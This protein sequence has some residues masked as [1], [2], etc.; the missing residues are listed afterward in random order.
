MDGE[1]LSDDLGGSVSL[2]G[3]MNGDG[4]ADL[5]VA[6]KLADPSGYSS[7]RSYVVFGKAGTDPV[8]P[9]DLAGGSGGFVID[10]EAEEHH[11]GAS[12]SAAGDVDGDGLADVVLGAPYA[13]PNDAYWAG[14]GYV[15]WGKTTTL[16]VQ[17]ALVA[18]G[19]GGFVIDGEYAGANSGLAVSGAG[20]VNGDGLADVIVAAPA[21]TP[22]GNDSGRTYV[23]FG[24]ANNTGVVLADVAA[25]LGGFAMDGEAADDRSG[26][27]VSGAG[28]V[29]GDGLADVIVAAFEADPNGSDSG[30]TYV[31]FGKMTTDLVALADVTGGV[32]GFAIDGEVPGD[33]SGYS[34]SGAGDVNGDGLDDIVVSARDASPTGSHAGRTYVVFGKEHTA[35]VLLS[36]VVQGIGGFA[37][38]GAAG[39][40]RSGWAVGRRRL[41]GRDRGSARG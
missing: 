17:L 1:D 19:Q 14:R 38:A 3:D 35:R 40:D 21:A 29:N 15:V 2:A 26:S 20:D 22:S 36:N 13:S 10:G 41:H 32:G 25:G 30:R 6:A 11:A 12:V 39:S 8:S 18:T 27:S 33:V 16:P 37:I 4:R 28:D 31:V 24:K 5:I 9:S 34:V 23:V 7:G